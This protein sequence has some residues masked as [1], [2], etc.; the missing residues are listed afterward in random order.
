MDAFISVYISMFTYLFDFCS[1]YLLLGYKPLN[2]VVSSNDLFLMFC[3]FNGPNW[4]VFL[5]VSHMIAVKWQLR[6]ESSK[7]TADVGCQ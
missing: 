5:G 4:A 7:V 2:I 1:S 3:V 6:L